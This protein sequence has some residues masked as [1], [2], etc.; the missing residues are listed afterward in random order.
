MDKPDN[1]N[2]TDKNESV[3][4][5]T[6]EILKGILKA[7]THILRH[8]YRKYYPGIWILVKQNGGS[9]EDADYV[10]QDSTIVIYRKL[11][12]GDLE[13]NTSLDTY[14]YSI[15]RAI[16][17]QQL[18]KREIKLSN[19]SD[20]QPFV[21]VQ[22]SIEDMAEEVERFKD[23]HRHF[24][25]LSSDCQKILLLSHRK[26]PLEVITKKMDLPSTEDCQ[27]KIRHCKDLLMNRI[28]FDNWLRDKGFE[29]HPN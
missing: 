26:V 5:S 17:I 7:D 23:Y 8:F 29:Y 15:S 19:F 12:D 4:I 10:F 11:R 9:D 24:K 6:D 28:H 25:S 27:R 18:E 14:L 20:S 2:Y 22:V 21:D 13:M 3:S 1:N 16:W